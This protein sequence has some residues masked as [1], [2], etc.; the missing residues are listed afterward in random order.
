MDGFS[1]NPIFL[2]SKFRHKTSFNYVPMLI[3]EL[4]L[5]CLF[6]FVEK[7]MKQLVFRCIW[8]NF[9]FFKKWFGPLEMAKMIK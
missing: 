9:I 4:L 7:Y 1:K 2:T 5:E 8:P 6:Y 3:Y